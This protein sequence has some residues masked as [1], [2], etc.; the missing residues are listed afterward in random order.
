MSFCWLK[1]SWTFP[2]KNSCHKH[3]DITLKKEQ[4]C[5]QKHSCTCPDSL[6]NIC[7]LCWSQTA[8]NTHG[9]C[10]QHG[11]IA[12]NCWNTISSWRAGSSSNSTTGPS[13]S[14]SEN[15]VI[16]SHYMFMRFF[17]WMS[18]CSLWHIWWSSCLPALSAPPPRLPLLLSPAAAPGVRVQRSRSSSEHNMF[19]FVL[20]GLFL[21]SAARHARL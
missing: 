13:A 3:P 19:P 16:V 11:V 7:L 2:V 9:C 5:S 8:N 21:L 6:W 14:R 18:V 1:H 17:V 4:F 12:C 10:H 20:T 15:C